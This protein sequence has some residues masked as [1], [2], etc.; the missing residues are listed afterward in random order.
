MKLLIL[1][2]FIPK[3]KIGEKLK[4]LIE[5]SDYILFNLEG[6]P[7]FSYKRPCK[8]QILPFWYD[9]LMLFLEKFG[10]EKFIISLANNHIL[11]NSERN[12]YILTNKFK[13]NSIKCIGTKET[14]YIILE[15][16]LFLSFV[17]W[18]TGI[19]RKHK[20][21][22][23]TIDFSYK[24]IYEIINEHKDLK[25]M[26]YPH[27]GMDLYPYITKNHLPFI[28]NILKNKNV[29]I[30]GHHPHLIIDDKVFDDS[31][32]FIFSL[33]NTYIPH[34]NYYKKYGDYVRYSKCIYYKDTDIE[35]KTLYYN[36]E[37]LEISDCDNNNFSY[38]KK[39]KVKSRQ[40]IPKPTRSVILNVFIKIILYFI[41][42][43]TTSK[44]YI[45]IKI[46]NKK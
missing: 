41:N 26:L 42:W 21:Y 23:N 24:K 45:K 32:R 10:K 14:P 6:S 43:V 34:P 7:N 4:K 25:I 1:S 28:K 18:E 31:Y 40:F 16:H 9:D 5:K 35:V 15:D 27:W 46:R 44:V 19:K 30:Y 3:V 29:F 13:E 36:D 11:D 37:N 2:D 38:N 22:L 17:S 20:K 12:F 39:I 33:G 8:D